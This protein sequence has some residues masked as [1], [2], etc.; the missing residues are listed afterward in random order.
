MVLFCFIIVINKLPKFQSTGPQSGFWDFPSGS[1]SKE[2]AC[3]AEDLGLIS[4]SGRV[5]GE[6]NGNLLY[7]ICLENSWT[8][9]LGRLIVEGVTNSWAR[10]SK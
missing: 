7:C 2:S 4:G 3:N 1:G 9:E 5:P 8:E 6:G 10:L